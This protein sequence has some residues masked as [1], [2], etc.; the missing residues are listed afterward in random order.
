[1]AFLRRLSSLSFLFV[2]A[3]STEAA[4]LEAV[5]DCKAETKPPSH[6]VFTLKD[7]AVTTQGQGGDPYNINNA[8]FLEWKEKSEKNSIVFADRNAGLFL[9]ISTDAKPGEETG[10]LMGAIL[11]TDSRQPVS[12]G[13]QVA[14]GS[15]TG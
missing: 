13:C 1:M 6:Y 12:F 11:S 3:A 14:K 10:M 9:L 5:L 7:T 8:K 15:L 2:A 4:A